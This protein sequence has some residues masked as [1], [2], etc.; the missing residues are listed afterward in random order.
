PAAEQDDE[1]NLFDPDMARRLPLRLLVVEDNEINQEVLV[2]ML[3][4]LGYQ[5]NI[6]ENGL[7]A[8]ETLQHETYDIILMDVQMPEMDGL[9]TT[10]RIRSEIAPNQQPCII[11]V[12]ANVVR[13]EREECFSAGMDDYISKPID[14]RQLI[15]AL[16]RAGASH[17]TTASGDSRTQPV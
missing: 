5:A 2:Q 9:A 8:L 7:R 3:A 14:P 17:P 12:T 6:A 10:R 15:A 1:E 13:E 16:E 4:Q 11:A